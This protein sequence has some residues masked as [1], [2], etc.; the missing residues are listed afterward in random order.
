MK[1]L[2]SFLSGLLLIISAKAQTI[3]KDLP[4]FDK[5]IGSPLINVVLLEGD[6][7]S[8]RME[9]AGVQPE[10]INIVSRGKTLHLYLEGA[11]MST[12]RKNGSWKEN[13]TYWEKLYPNAKLTAYVTYRKLK[14]VQIRGEQKLVC[15]DTLR[16][17]NFTLELLGENQVEMAGLQTSR[18]KVILYG[19]NRVAIDGGYAYAQRYK[20]FGENRVTAEHLTGETIRTSLFGESHLNL[21][22][23]ES[24]HM[25]AF[26]ESYVSNN[27]KG[28]L[29]KRLTLGENTLRQK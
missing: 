22:A 25:T 13:G 20:A 1:A 19:E 17:D 14:H 2:F 6:R 4:A 18:L 29:H 9:Y 15:R 21:N 23:S 24:L 11:K 26:G 10:K 7:E 28:R 3:T 16:S 8:I 5:F 27:G 12:S